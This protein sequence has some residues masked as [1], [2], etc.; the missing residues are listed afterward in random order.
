MHTKDWQVHGKQRRQ[1]GGA[2]LSFDPVYNDDDNYKDNDNDED[3][4]F[5]DYDDEKFLIIMVRWKTRC[6]ATSITSARPTA[7]WCQNFVRFDKNIIW[8][9]ACE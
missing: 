7:N 8:N 2:L 9:I 1:Y 5:I 6:S 3:D 4:N